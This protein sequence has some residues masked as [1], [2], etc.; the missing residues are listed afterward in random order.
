MVHQAGL[1][2][3]W[4]KFG[5]IRLKVFTSIYFKHIEI[6]GQVSE[7]KAYTRAGEPDLF[8]ICNKKVFLQLLFLPYMTGHRQSQARVQARPKYSGF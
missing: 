5:E 2:E 6:A 1:E 7:I 3:N 8:N 4:G